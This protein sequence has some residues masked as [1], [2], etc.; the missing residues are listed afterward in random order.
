MSRKD[1]AIIASGLVS[2][3]QLGYIKKKDI[4]NAIRVM[5]NELSRDNYKFDGSKFKDYILERI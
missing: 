2:S 5:S 1:Y 3:I 4:D